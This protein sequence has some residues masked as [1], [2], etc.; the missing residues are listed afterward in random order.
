MGKYKINLIEYIVLSEYIV[1]TILALSFIGG[2]I[3]LTEY[4]DW[5]LDIMLSCLAW[6]YIL[7]FLEA[8]QIRKQDIK[9]SKDFTF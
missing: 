4:A 2:A 8:L 1:L 3:F 9:D 7:F 6:M 5:F